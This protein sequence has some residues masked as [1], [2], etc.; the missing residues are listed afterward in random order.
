MKKLF[1]I[2][3]LILCMPGSM[4]ALSP[5]EKEENEL[6]VPKAYRDLREKIFSE[7][8]VTLSDNI[9]DNDLVHVL[10]ETWIGDEIIMLVVKKDGTAKQY[11]S[12]GRKVTNK[13]KPEKQKQKC[14]EYFKNA[15][16]ALF[17]SYKTLDRGL[18]VPGVSLFYFFTVNRVYKSSINHT[19]PK[20]WGKKDTRGVWDGW[21]ESLFRLN[22]HAMEC[23]AEAEK[24]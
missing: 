21:G 8:S 24:K 3:T 16:L 2:L 7:V 19:Y 18:P 14:L 6:P 20:H 17:H 9:G 12:S 1:I 11:S 15:E 4:I 10:M 23:M 22:N 5:N 13:E